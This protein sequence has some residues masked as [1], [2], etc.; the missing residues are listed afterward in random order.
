MFGTGNEELGGTGAMIIE[1]FSFRL[2]EGTDL[3]CGK[4]YFYDDQNAFSGLNIAFYKK[5]ITAEL[6]SSWAQLH[7]HYLNLVF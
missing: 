4:V 6:A 7:N 3:S 1:A 2:S 5:A